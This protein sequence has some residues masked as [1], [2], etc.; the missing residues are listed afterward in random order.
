M[1]GVSTSQIRTM[2]V[3]ARHRRDIEVTCYWG[4]KA[5]QPF[6]QVL[7][8]FSRENWSIGAAFSLLE[9]RQLPAYIGPRERY[10]SRS[11]VLPAR[12][13]LFNR[14]K[15]PAVGREGSAVLQWR[16]GLRTESCAAP[17]PSHWNMPSSRC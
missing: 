3:I 10:T 12:D 13:R 2:H 4:H 14:C 7:A 8:K 5:V 16:R 1:G 6:A 15:S 11:M 9:M 17:I